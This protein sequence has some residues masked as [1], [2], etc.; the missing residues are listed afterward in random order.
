MLNIITRMIM[1]GAQN[2]VLDL[3]QRID[4][5]KFESFLLSGSEADTRFSKLNN[6]ESNNH[7]LFLPELVREIN[8][9]MDVKAVAKLTAILCS[10]KP[11]IVHCHTYKAGVI[12]CIAA[13]LAGVKAV[14]F[15]P[16]GH[17]FERGAN[18]PGVPT[19]RFSLFGL[20]WLTRFA[21]MC[22]DKVTALSDIDMAH[23]VRI[24]LAPAG[25]YCVI[26]NG[27]NLGN[28]KNIS[29]GSSFRKQLG[30]SSDTAIVGTVGRLT[31]EKGYRFLVEAMAKVRERFSKVIL[32]IVGK[33]ALE[34]ELV[35]LTH[36]HFLQDCVRF[37]GEVDDVAL[38]LSAMDVYVQPSLYE[39]QGLAMIE[40]MAAR[41]SVVATNVGGIP[42]VVKDGETGLLVPPADPTALADAIITLLKDRDMAKRFGEAGYQRVEKFYSVDNMVRNYENLYLDLL[43]VSH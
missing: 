37:L 25:K 27:I 8:I 41:K 12:G 36:K 5:G 20:Y 10:V 35:S 19:N 31:S 13:K 6:I 14:I 16:H 42:D 22:A 11:D 23:Q 15:T 28:M 40:A 29:N 38:P 21:Q 7:L 4:K 33:G 32:L 3:L 17:I 9:R 43:G 30:I 39:S 2:I 18:I 34:Q 24:S 26:R 1:G